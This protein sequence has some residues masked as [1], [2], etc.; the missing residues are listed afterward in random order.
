MKR[1]VLLLFAAA[2]V[3]AACGSAEEVDSP[4][5][6]PGGAPS[7]DPDA[8]VTSSPLPPG[9]DTV[10]SPEPSIATPQ[11]G[12]VD[13]RPIGWEAAEPGMDDSSL[14]IYYWSGVEPCYVLDHVDV[15]YSAKEITVTLFEGRS[16]IDEDTAC[17]EIA[18]YK[19][20][21]VQLDEPIEGRRIADGSSPAEPPK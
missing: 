19:A 6:R 20:T 3:L 9:D 12:Q 4:G 17:I 10:P 13:V 5:V 11:P 1:T 21:V 16:P 8:P 7:S 14:T 18:V 2:L 15:E